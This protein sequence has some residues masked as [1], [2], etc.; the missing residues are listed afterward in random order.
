MPVS[1][2]FVGAPGDY[3]ALE[4]MVRTEQ[5]EGTGMELSSDSSADAGAR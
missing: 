4:V 3:K 2:A 5:L 1:G